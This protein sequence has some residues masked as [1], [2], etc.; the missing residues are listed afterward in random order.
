MTF[1]A[2]IFANSFNDSLSSV[3]SGLGIENNHIKDN[4]NDLIQNLNPEQKEAVTHIDGPLLV[5]A[6]AGSGKTRVLTNRIAYLIEEHDVS[7]YQILAITFTNK[8]AAEMVSR[9]SKIVGPVANKMWVSTFHSAC[10]RILRYD[11]DVVG[12]KN[13]F[14]IYDTTDA[15][16][17]VDYAR[18][19][20]GA[21]PKRFGAKSVYRT[22]S[23]LKNEMISPGVALE[24]AEMDTQ[25]TIAKIYAEYEHRLRNANAV[26]F[27]DLLLKVVEMFRTSEEKLEK[28]QERFQH[29]L[30]DEF[31]DT[32]LA[33]F[34]LVSKIATKHRNITVV[35]D[36]DQSIY[37]FRG[38][39]HQNFQRF[40]ETFE[41]A[42]TV[43]LNTNYRSTE[44]ILQAANSVISNNSNRI[45]KELISD[46]GVGEPI[47]VFYAAS[48]R[49]ES[50]Y[51]I[52]QLQKESKKYKFND[53]AIF[54]RTNAQS[55]LLEEQLIR[56]GIP[57][58][59]VGGTK[60][61]ER[62][63]IKD[64][65]SYL[66]I[67]VNPADE[68]SW[69]RIINEPK[70]G[71]GDTSVS[72]IAQ[73]ARMYDIS[74]RQA[75]ERPNEYALPKRAATAALGVC[76]LFDNAGNGEQVK[77][78]QVLEFLL[79]ESGYYKVLND[80]GSFESD[81]RLENLSELLNQAK[82]FDLALEKAAHL[83]EVVLEAQ[84]GEVSKFEEN[85]DQDKTIDID[86]PIERVSAFLEAVSLL[87]ES[88]KSNEND[89]AI[90]LMTLHTA[91]GLEYQVVAIVGLE[92]GLFPHERSLG[93]SS[94]LEEER[95]LMYVGVTRAMEKLY[96]SCALSRMLYATPE[97][98]SPSRFL[99]EIPSELVNIIKDSESVNDSFASR[100]AGRSEGSHK[101]R[102]GSVYD[103]VVF[104]DLQGQED[105][106]LD[107]DPRTIDFI[108]SNVVSSSIFDLPG[109][110]KNIQKIPDDFDVTGFSIATK[111]SHGKYGEGIIAQVETHK[112]G[113]IA[114][115]VIFEEENKQR[116]FMASL[117]P[118][119]EII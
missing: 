83:S 94:E 57:Y 38:A 97:F 106:Y 77:I 46:K 92:E 10:S 100:R 2:N 107:A 58:R 53:M 119:L 56:Q 43:V 39:D 9:V 52:G 26:D 78:A 85:F 112:S 72:R 36:G 6:G 111:V 63:E 81:G 34:E 40:E 31:Q 35:G 103:D 51:V 75:C 15:A 95:R 25:T 29:V 86:N 23:S 37:K 108:T 55:R 8:A 69:R 30:V 67:F 89:D 33:Q 101:S 54:Y 1:P 21:D 18:R 65:I 88:D 79:N 60:F 117:N 3:V 115:T 98:Y 13:G 110:N 32:N 12:V 70:R 87:S 4:S 114:I 74:F 59:I 48:D 45:K 19:D 71:L 80:E 93:D 102:Y 5:V 47:I 20:I 44:N 113:D 99:K 105:E 24:R 50:Q 116:T 84:V 11:G 41:E 90:T 76:A 28:Y 17:L 96:L 16:R 68:A 109:R 61:F 7:P 66:R 104:D 49:S 91:K 14:T 27:D 62:K 118:P 82:E 42:K 73:F 22:I 64:A